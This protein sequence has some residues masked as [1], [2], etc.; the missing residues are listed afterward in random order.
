MRTVCSG[1][2][3]KLFKPRGIAFN[4]ILWFLRQMQSGIARVSDLRIPQHCG[5]GR[6]SCFAHCI[7]VPALRVPP[8]ML[9]YPID[10][11]SV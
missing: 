4:H 5:F 3:L 11:V 2:I 9:L 1:V 10:A 7:L 6:Q 8:D